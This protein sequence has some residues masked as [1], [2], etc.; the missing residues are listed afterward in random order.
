MCKNRSRADK[1]RAALCQS[2]DMETRSKGHVV[3]LYSPHSPRSWGHCSQ[4]SAWAHRGAASPTPLFLPE[5]S[6]CLEQ[7]ACVQE[8]LGKHQ[9]RSL[10]FLARTTTVQ[11]WV[12]LPWAQWAHSSCQVREQLSCI[13]PTAQLSAISFPSLFF[14]FHSLPCHLQNF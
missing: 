10:P 8:D 6:W 2:H 12:A 14:F 13:S 4:C 11:P 7:P 3:M 5:V 1:D 9:A